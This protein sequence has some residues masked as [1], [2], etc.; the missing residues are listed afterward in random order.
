MN[1]PLEC[2]NSY[3]G[4][5][6]WALSD[7]A[8]PR[9]LVFRHEDICKRITWVSSLPVP[10]ALIFFNLLNISLGSIIL[11]LTPSPLKIL[12]CTALIQKIRPKAWEGIYWS[13]LSSC[14]AAPGRLLLVYF[15]LIGL[16]VS[17]FFVSHSNQLRKTLEI[18]NL[19][20]IV[21]L[22]ASKRELFRTVSFFLNASTLRARTT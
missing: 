7:A 6:L 20:L 3:P 19:D 14:R 17:L 15:W 5:Y 13:F 22:T 10:P 4:A 9:G 16:T 21:P 8:V 1:S 2:P 18:L 11:M 12:L